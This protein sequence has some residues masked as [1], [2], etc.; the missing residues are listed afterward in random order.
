MNCEN[1]TP[2]FSG[3]TLSRPHWLSRNVKQNVVLCRD[4]SPSMTGQKAADASAASLDLV[5]ELAQPVN[6]D[7]FFIGI[8]DFAISAKVVH[9]LK[10]ATI[11]NEHLQPLTID[12]SEKGTNITT[13]LE[14]ALSLLEKLPELPED[15]G[16]CH[17]LRPV[18]LCLTDGCHNTGSHPRDVADRLKQKADLVTVAFGNDAD[19]A[20]LQELA[21]TPQHCYRC[22]NGH[23]LRSFLAAV[24]TTITTTMAA[25]IPA[26]SA[27]ADVNP[28]Q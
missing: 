17:F 11:L 18:V 12:K 24:G 15:Q 3:F 28:K 7:G 23:Q 2:K 21:T 25:G 10:K 13:S 6:K 9:P 1:K 26:T 19:K 5:E 20:L 14:S 4:T 22:S 27:L 16:E 8:V